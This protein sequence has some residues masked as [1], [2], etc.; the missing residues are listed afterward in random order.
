[1]VYISVCTFVFQVALGSRQQKDFS[2]FDFLS[3]AATRTGGFLTIRFI[4]ERQAK[5]LRI[6]IFIVFGLTLP[7][8]EL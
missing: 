4:T 2:V 7:G 8:I 3:I 6:Q 1:M 5:K